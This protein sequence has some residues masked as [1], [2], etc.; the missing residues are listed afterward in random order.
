MQP[1]TVTT[2]VQRPIDEVYDHLD[3]LGNHEA[4]TDHFMVDWEL[5]GPPRGVGAKLH[6]NVKAAGTKQ[7]IDLEVYEAEAPTRIVERTVAAGGKRITR[8][9][10]RL[11]P[12]GDDA[13]KVSFEIAY[14]QT[15]LADK[16][17]APVIQSLLRKM[18]QQ[19]MDRLA[20]QLATP[21]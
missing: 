19:A 8:G 3:V 21:A 11:E 10:Y 5:S 20:A 12:A 7:P 17:L 1:I 2:V 9:T 16:L 4:F 6:A 18:N 15:P 14:E 13:T